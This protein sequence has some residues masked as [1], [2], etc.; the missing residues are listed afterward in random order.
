MKEKY[1]EPEYLPSK[2]IIQ[3]WKRDKVLLRQ[4]KIKTVHQHKTNPEINVRGSSLNR[5]EERICGRERIPLVKILAKIWKQ[6]K[7]SS[8]DKWIK[9]QCCIHN[10]MHTHTH[11]HTHNGILHS[12][13]KEWKFAIYNNMDGLEEFSLVNKSN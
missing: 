6:T 13:K 12:H 2:I 9:K 1:W 3:N 5:K 10:C 7:C 4:A 11:T 8:K